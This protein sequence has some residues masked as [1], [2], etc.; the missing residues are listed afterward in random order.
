MANHI[1]EDK[2]IEGSGVHEGSFPREMIPIRRSGGEED[3][4]GLIIWMASASGG[5]LNGA[6][7]LTDGGR[8]SVVPNTY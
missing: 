1:F 7:M 3:F 2:G 5:Y 6:I 4:A 8:V